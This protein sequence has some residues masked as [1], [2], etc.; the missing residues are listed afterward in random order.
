[1]PTYVA[2]LRGVNV[3][4]KNKVAMAEL[5]DV[6]TRLGF[7]DVTTYIQSGNVLF[8]GRQVREPVLV[9][10]IQEGLREAF[11]LEV[12]VVIRTPGELRD[13]VS[14]N[15]FAGAEGG[16]AKTHVVFLESAPSPEKVALLD[17][18]RSPPDAFQVVGREVYLSCPHGMAKTKLTIDYFERRLQTV[19][20]ARNWN[21]V[22]TL[23]EL[24][25][26]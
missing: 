25:A 15:P 6:V 1:M 16:V 19:A 7:Q 17:P 13:V 5:R 14:N 9:A 20:T 3:S 24:A 4:G 18:A 22:T 12:G 26:G 8:K 21:T 2:L 23:L 10:R 11:G